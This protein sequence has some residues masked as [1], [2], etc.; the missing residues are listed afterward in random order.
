MAQRL[1]SEERARVE[2]MTAAGVGVKETAR[3]LGRHC[4]N[5]LAIV[6][7]PAPVS[8]VISTVAGRWP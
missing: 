5:A 7:L 8:P 1:S 4:S 6:D 2:A 3:C